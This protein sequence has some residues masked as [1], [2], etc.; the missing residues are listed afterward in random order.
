MIAFSRDSLRYRL[1]LSLLGVAAVIAG[2]G[3]SG[4]GGWQAFAEVENEESDFS[5][6]TAPSEFDE[7]DVALGDG[8]SD[9]LPFVDSATPTAV[10]T[11]TAVP[12]PTPVPVP[13]MELADALIDRFDADGLSPT[14]L[15]D[16][17][18]FNWHC[19]T[20]KI[21]S[22]ARP[23]ELG[24]FGKRHLP[25][26]GQ[27]FVVVQLRTIDACRGVKRTI[28]I[29]GKRLA[30]R[31]TGPGSHEEYFALTFGAEA[32]S[33]VLEYSSAGLSTT[34]DLLEHR[35]AEEP[36]ILY[37]DPFG[38]QLQTDV[39]F[40]TRID[41]TETRGTVRMSSQSASV[42]AFRFADWA[43]TQIERSE[44]G[45]A[46]VEVGLGIE[47]IGEG[48]LADRD[49]ILIDDDGT[50]YTATLLWRPNYN[51]YFIGLVYF[52]VPETFRSGTMRV[53]LDN[54]R[55]GGSELQP[56][57]RFVD[58]PISFRV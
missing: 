25:A 41:I 6:V 55:W 50:R 3:S 26:D 49:V 9:E 45:R 13:Q 1:W 5:I 19:V 10:P 57:K 46:W 52:D 15:G 43:A 28:V 51:R 56:A 2:C 11:A 14:M 40:E 54:V 22:T 32:N 8:S 23:S 16:E 31:D 29:D 7:E 34:Y 20:S 47:T 4:D 53:R 24:I 37:V 38:R 44:L 21:E 48:R 17:G 36:A 12:T 27:Q 42:A 35:R 18:R 39:N 58:I 33:V 30:L